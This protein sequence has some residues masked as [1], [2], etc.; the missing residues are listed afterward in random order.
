MTD[1]NGRFSEEERQQICR[2]LSARGLRQEDAEDLAQMTMLKAWKKQETFRQESGWR[3]WLCAIA[4]REYLMF[5]R[6]QRRSLL[7]PMPEE[8]EA[9][10][11]SKEDLHRQVSTHLRVRSIVREAACL[12]KEEREAIDFLLADD[13]LISIAKRLKINYVTLRSRRNRAI[14]HLREIINATVKRRPSGR[15]YKVACRG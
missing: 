11:A 9:L 6:R 14:L 15:G 4:H 2:F 5:L 3:T 8:A 1:A 7:L 10:F 13:A 12:P